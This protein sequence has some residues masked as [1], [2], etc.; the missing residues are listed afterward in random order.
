MPI[1]IRELVIRAEVNTK[2]SFS[3]PLYP[4]QEIKNELKKEII[5]A[6]MFQIKDLIRESNQ[7]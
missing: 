4:D 3:G 2:T 1:E 5:E 7:R 6:C